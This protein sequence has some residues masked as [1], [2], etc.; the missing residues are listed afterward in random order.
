MRSI[1]AVLLSL[2]VLMSPV[3]VCAAETVVPSISPETYKLAKSFSSAYC[4]ALADG[5]TVEASTDYAV[6]EIKW[7][8]LKT[9]IAWAWEH[10]KDNEENGGNGATDLLAGFEPM[11]TSRVKQCSTDSQFAEFLKQDLDVATTTEDN[12]NLESQG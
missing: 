9:A 2:V 5:L 4:E 1:V 10:R 6:S 12:Q 8:T 3:A 11:V 7:R